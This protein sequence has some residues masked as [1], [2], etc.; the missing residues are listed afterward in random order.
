MVLKL[1]FRFGEYEFYLYLCTTNTNISITPTNTHQ[2]MKNES[3][4]FYKDW[5]E[6]IKALPEEMRLKAVE[7]VMD[8]AFEGAE[9][10]DAIL[11]FA[12]AQMRA[13]IIRDRKRYED[14]RDKR[15]QAV[16][17]RW[18][19]RKQQ[20][21]ESCMVDI[22]SEDESEYTLADECMQA[23]SD[24][25]TCVQADAPLYLND[26]VNGNGNVNGNVNGNGNDNGKDKDKSLLSAAANAAIT[27]C[28]GS[29][30]GAE[31]L[32]LKA[33]IA[34]LKSDEAWHE[35][36]QA[37]FKLAGDEVDGYL[38][39]FK[40]EMVARGRHVVNPRSLFVTWLGKC[41]KE[42][43]AASPAAAAPGPGLGA[44]EYRDS[45]GRRTYASSG[46]TVPDWAPPRPSEAHWWSERSNAWCSMI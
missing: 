21:A 12:T 45:Q 28:A 2:I 36:M 44:G 13:F 29:S 25:C 18:D 37:K 1:G 14:I 9:P 33:K 40:A 39:D 15:R 4:V 11:K 3:V 20:Q 35:A 26:N 42:S 22:C 38:D 24:V 8:F 6:A 17:A 16:K 43:A 27:A 32:D 23:D 10:Q 5:W 41:L 34:K 46:V 7:A 31:V 19:K 30:R